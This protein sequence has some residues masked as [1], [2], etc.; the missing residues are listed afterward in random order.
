MLKLFKFY[1]MHFG[2]GESFMLGNEFAEEVVKIVSI[3]SF[4][5]SGRPVQC[6]WVE[7][8]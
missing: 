4:P 8:I 2:D 6:R 1:S 3:E 5:D 7:V